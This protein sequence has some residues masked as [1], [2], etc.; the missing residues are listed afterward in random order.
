MLFIFLY[1]TDLSI[2]FLSF[3]FMADIYIIYIYVIF[4]FFKRFYL[5]IHDRQREAETQAEGEKQA[6]CWEP[7]LGLD[8]GSP[9]SHPRLKQ[10]QTA[11]PPGLPMFFY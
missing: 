5:F 2:I 10:C 7:D 9:G 11:G 6:P 1:L 3:F 8:P 4:S